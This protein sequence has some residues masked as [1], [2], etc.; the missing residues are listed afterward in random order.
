MSPTSTPPLADDPYRLAPHR[1]AAALRPRA[2]RPT[3][4]RPRSPGGCAIEV[5]VVEPTARDRAQRHRAR[6]PW[7]PAASTAAAVDGHPRR[8]DRAAHPRPADRARGRAVDGRRSP[9]PASSTTS[10]AA[11]TAAPSPTTTAT[12]AGD[13]HHPDR[14]DRRPPG[15]PVLGRA[16]LQGRLRGHPRRRPGAHS[17]SRTGR[18]SSAPSVATASTWSA[19]PTRCRCRTYLVAFVVGPL[20]VTEPVDVDG[21]PLRVVARARQGP[22][23]RVRR[24]RSAPSP[25]DWFQR[26]LRHPLPGRQDRPRRPPRLRLRGHG[27]PRLRHLP[28]EPAAR[29][30]G[31]EHPAP[32]SRASPT[33]SPTRSPTCGSATSSR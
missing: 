29:R 22:P 14:G 4:T 8:G 7:T 11:S 2:R 3:S 10:C 9:S 6:D 19:S 17:P 26:L 30:P 21:V 18:R 20:E 12:D 5:D 25:C 32:S 28:R 23:H 1:R 31:H 27:E 13:R 15:V 24:S 33:S 16:R